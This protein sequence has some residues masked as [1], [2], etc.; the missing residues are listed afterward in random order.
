VAQRVHAL[1]GD[2]EGNGEAAFIDE[3]RD[4]VAA[5]T[6]GETWAISWL[7]WTVGELDEAADDL[8]AAFMV[9][10]LRPWVASG[11]A[12]EAP[13]RAARKLSVSVR[14]AIV[15]RR[16]AAAPAFRCRER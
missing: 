12:E 14:S 13:A 11:G 5:T 3:L 16:R 8:A 2:L 10:T 4:H 9:A 15:K 6:S 7:S 1:A